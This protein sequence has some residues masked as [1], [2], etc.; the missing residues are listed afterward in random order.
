MVKRELKKV[1]IYT[2]GACSGNP[3]PGGYGVILKYRQHR[4][5]ISQ[6][7]RK[8]TNNR[9]E[10]MAAVAGLE[11][12]QDRCLVLLYTDSKYLVDSITKGWVKKWRERG[13]I[14]GK[15]ENVL[16]PDLWEKLLQLC[17]YHQVEIL[18]VKGHAGNPEN[19]RADRLATQAIQ[20]ENKSIDK[21]YEEQN[22]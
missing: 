20:K 12:L 1:E 22:E 5:E 18:W 15:K 4:K 2:D 14:R 8:T 9:M 19:E 7:F 17:E 11:A 6:G 16:N 13:W 3:G 10:L 21:F